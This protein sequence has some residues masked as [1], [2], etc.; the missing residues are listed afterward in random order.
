MAAAAMAHDPVA[1]AP[2][3]DLLADADDFAC[4][5]D[6]SGH[7]V[8]GP[9]L[10]HVLDLAKVEARRK[11]SDQHFVGTRIWIGKIL[12]LKLATVGAWYNAYCLH[13]VSC[14]MAQEI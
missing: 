7:R 5:L 10:P 8:A 9:V 11:N 14:L 4:K 2:A 13:P 6:A 12:H 1:L 3:A